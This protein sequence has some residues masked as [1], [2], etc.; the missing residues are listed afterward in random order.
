MIRPTVHTIE[1]TLLSRAAPA[2][3]YQRT[4]SYWEYRD[5][6]SYIIGQYFDKYRYKPGLEPTAQSAQGF[7]PRP[8]HHYLQEV[9]NKNILYT[10]LNFGNKAS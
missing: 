6:H 7:K 1:V 3:L 2:D 8:A 4:H 5:S 9:C 10:P